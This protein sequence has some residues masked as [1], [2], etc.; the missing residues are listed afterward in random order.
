MEIKVN[1]LAIINAQGKY[2]K[3]CRENNKIDQTPEIC[4]YFG[5]A[6]LRQSRRDPN[7]CYASMP[8]LHCPIDKIATEVAPQFSNFKT[9][10]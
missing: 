2:E 10:K 3:D 4:G 5:R 9:N 6:C 8:C 1:L 7:D